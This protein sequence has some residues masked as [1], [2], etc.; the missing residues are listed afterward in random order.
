MSEI[1]KKAVCPYDCP[2]TCGFKAVIEDGKLKK[3]IPDERHPASAGILCRKMRNYERSVNSPD[4][5]LTPLMRTGKKGSGE[6]KKISWDEA[7]DIIGERWQDIIS[8]Y[9]AGAVV[10]CYYSG[11]MSDIQR[12]CGEAFF[13]RMGA[14]PLVKTLCSTAKGVGYASV[15]GRTACLDPR[16]IGG[17]DMYIVWGS[18][19]TATRI[20]SMPDIVRAKN[21][22]KR[23]VLIEVCAEAMKNFCDEKILVKPGTDGA[24]ALAMMHVLVRE[25]MADEDFLRENT[26]GYDEFKETLPEYTPEW[27]EKITGV[28]AEAIE[29]L[30]VEYGSAKAPVIILGSGNSRYGNGA[31]TVRLI[32]ILSH[33][34]GAWT[35]GGGICGC[36]TTDSAYVKGELITRPDL[37]TEK[38]PSVNINQLGVA[39]KD[40]SVKTLY[41]YASNPANSV[42]D[43]RAVIEGLSREDLFTVVHERFMTDTAR[44]ADIILPATFSVEQSDIYQAYGYCTLATARKAVEP[45]GESKSNWDTFRLLAQKMGYDDEHFKLTEDEMLDKILDDP[46]PAVSALS[47]E[48][49]KTLREGGWVAM[50]F[51]DHHTWKT[52][53]GKIQIANEKLKDRLPVFIEAHGGGYPLRLVSVPSEHTLNSIFNERDDMKK[54]RGELKLFINPA[55]AEERGINNGDG[56][57]CFNDLAE[58]AF[59]AAVT[60]NVARGAVAAV[61]IYD[62]KN[63]P[64]GLGVNAL[65]HDRL[66]DRGEATTINDNTVDI[67]LG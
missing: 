17:A 29:K 23:V 12:H 45:A 8:R 15:M 66:S 19:M 30:A 27:A 43:T 33:F 51:T 31:M 39:I 21:E 24:L 48:D 1:I 26:D 42:S 2:T 20:Q 56:I 18:N 61:G 28:P 5:I 34:T 36:T 9:G 47:V 65:Q 67:R 50:P 44:Y 62:M 25:G 41:V 32:T 53:T 57:I 59:K 60:E 16:E 4:R 11:V 7:V 13:N 64:S 54:A 40:E 58:A 6:F 46:T 14:R 10:Y 52:K 37:R 22:G 49:K 3:I 63:T 55:D 38:Q 35:R